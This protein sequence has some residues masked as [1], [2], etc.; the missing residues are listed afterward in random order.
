MLWLIFRVQ[1][2]DLYSSENLRWSALLN[3]SADTLWGI[4]RVVN[5]KTAR[6]ANVCGATAFASEYEK[7]ANVSH[8]RANT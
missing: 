2:N 4:L 1:V 8:W 5:G 6:R 7:R 3:R